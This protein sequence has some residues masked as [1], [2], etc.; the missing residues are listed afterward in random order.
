MMIGN[1][2]QNSTNFKVIVNHDNIPLTNSVKYLG[3]ILDNK[4]T[5][6][7]HIE[8]ISV[9]LSRASGMIFKLRHYVPLST[10]KLIY[11]S[12]LFG[13][14]NFLVDLHKHVENIKVSNPNTSVNS[15]ATSLS[16]VFE[17]ALNKHAPLRPMSRREK[18]LSQKPWI[19]KGILK[20]I[21]TKNK[22]FRIHY[23]SNDLDKNFFINNS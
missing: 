9:K 10:L 20:S 12:V 16:S 23:G 7:P 3:V 8:Q 5:W 18:R 19:S 15:N 1:E 14:E 4:L 17:L 11:Y 21:K 6:Q 22:L 2:M 13:I